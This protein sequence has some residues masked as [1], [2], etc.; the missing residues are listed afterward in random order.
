MK[1]RSP[2][3]DAKRPEKLA[4]W[5]C[6]ITPMRKFIGLPTILVGDPGIGKSEAISLLAKCLG[7]TFIRI[8]ASQ[9]QAG[10]LCL[11]I[12]WQPSPNS[13]PETYFA[14]PAWLV[15]LENAKRSVLFIDEVTAAMPAVINNLNA[16]AWDR[17]VV[18]HQLPPTTSVVCACNSV[19]QLMMGTELPLPFVNRYCWIDWSGP[20]VDEWTGWL[21]DESQEEDLP[22]LTVE[23]FSRELLKVKG[24]VAGFL[25]SNRSMFKQTP[26]LSSWNGKPYP[27]PRS[28]E[29]CIRGVAA[30]RALSFGT[31]VEDIIIRGTVGDGVVPAWHAWKRQLQ[32]PAPQD[33]I[34]GRSELPSRPDLLL[35]TLTNLIGYVVDHIDDAALRTAA[36]KVLKK[37][38]EHGK[39]FTYFGLWIYC[40]QLLKCSRTKLTDEESKLLREFASDTSFIELL[41]RV[42]EATE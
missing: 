39:E 33:L 9:L 28:W 26:Q 22:Q 23:E 21:F 41:K 24:E 34:S 16:I 8:V 35:P 20:T 27:T 5:I 10:D 3:S 6:I 42:T 13:P 2:K 19:E 30:T 25:R 40:R 11:P 36:L 17:L 4:L 38:E 12:A 37:A 32:I 18:I 31:S 15:S 29:L 7:A 14:K 1:K